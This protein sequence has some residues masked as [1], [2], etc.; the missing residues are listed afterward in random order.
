MS[1]ELAATAAS[2]PGPV[3]EP[4]S[5]KAK[6]GKS[7]SSS[8]STSS[9]AG[10]RASSRSRA[11]DSSRSD[12]VGGS[13]KGSDG[14]GRPRSEDLKAHGSG[15]AVDRVSNVA[16]AAAG[17]AGQAAAAAPAASAP[18]P[19]DAASSLAEAARNVT[20]AAGALRPSVRP[21]LL[22]SAYLVKY[23]AYL[24]QYYRIA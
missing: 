15:I 4:G 20:S 14:G 6:H 24:V 11:S 7:R 23:C 19:E 9:G 16:D 3:V 12:G 10:G 1:A 17:K 8:V 5:K 22:I 13:T 2:A 18:I 21:A